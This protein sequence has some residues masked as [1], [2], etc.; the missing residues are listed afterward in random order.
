MIDVSLCMIVKNESEVLD[1]CLKSIYDLVEEIIIVD[2]GSVDNTKEIARKYTDKIYDFKW[3]DDFAAA[4]NYAF[5]KATK[6]YIYSADADEVVDEV[7]RKKFLDLKKAMLPEIEIVQMIYHTDMTYNTTENF[8]RDLRPKLYKRLRNFTWINP[9]HETVRLEPVVYNSDIEILHMPTSNHC[10]RDLNL[11]EK[12]LEKEGELN[13]KLHMMYAREVYKSGTDEQLLKSKDYFENIL[14]KQIITNEDYDRAKEAIAV[15]SKIYNMEK[16]NKGLLTLLKYSV[17][18]LSY[19]EVRR[20]I[21]HNYD[22]NVMLIDGI[23]DFENEFRNVRDI[24][25]HVS[26]EL[27]LHIGIRL[28][29]EKMLEDSRKWLLRTIHKTRSIID[30]DSTTKIPNE[31]LQLIDSKKLIQI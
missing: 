12:I 1:R 26:A 31:Y 15:L 23:K 2:T 24:N 5:S 20:E 28:M 6:E 3:C 22:N 29:E 25:M 21:G 18:E 19:E 16:D 10:Q 13:N 8:T 11:F 4:R 9:I 27:S 17:S 7:N 30:V 14:H